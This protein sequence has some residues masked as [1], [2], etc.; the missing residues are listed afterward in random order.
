MSPMVKISSTVTIVHLQLLSTGDYDA[1]R[2]HCERPV[3]VSP[4]PL[5]AT[6]T[7]RV[8]QIKILSEQIG[9][10]LAAHADAHIFTSLPRAGTVRAAR[11]LA[12]SYGLSDGGFPG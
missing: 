7:S 8:E 11:L 2:E 3:C 4:A 12:R 9:A 10:Q 1:T 5:V 6:L